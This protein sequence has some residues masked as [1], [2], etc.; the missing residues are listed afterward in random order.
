[1]Q[2]LAVHGFNCSAYPT[3]H[4]YTAGSCVLH[5]CNVAAVAAAAGSHLGD[6]V[7]VTQQHTNLAGGHALLGQLADVLGD[8]QGKTNAYYEC[9]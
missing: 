5:V 4:R 8:L 7:A 3:K 6:T 1:M 2:L 9:E